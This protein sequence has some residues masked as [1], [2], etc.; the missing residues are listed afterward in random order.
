MIYYRG[1]YG[2]YYAAERAGCYVIVNV[3]GNVTDSGNVSLRYCRD[4][5]RVR[6]KYVPT[7]L[8]PVLRAH[9]KTHEK[10]T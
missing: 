10:Q 6:L 5:T 8:L 1:R 7:D 9:L 3:Q 4:F 2:A